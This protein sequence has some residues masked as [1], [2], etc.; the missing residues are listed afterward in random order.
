MEAF[1]SY[2]FTWEDPQ[3]LKSVLW[4]INDAFAMLGMSTFCSLH[5]EQF[6]RDNNMNAEE[7]YEYCNRRLEHSDILFAFIKSEHESKGMNLELDEAI[8]LNKKV[9]LAIKEWLDY[10]R[11]RTHAISVIEFQTI[12]HLVEN[13]HRL[14]R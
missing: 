12:D 5:L 14:V 1:I 8:K 9:I 6:F 4:R 3:E 11:F 7:I 13:L 10:P 2:R